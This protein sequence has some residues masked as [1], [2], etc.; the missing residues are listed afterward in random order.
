MHVTVVNQASEAI[1]YQVRASR[2]RLSF[3]GNPDI[4]RLCMY[5]GISYCNY[6]QKSAN[7]SLCIEDLTTP[8]NDIGTGIDIGVGEKALIKFVQLNKEMRKRVTT[9]TVKIRSRF[10]KF[11]DYMEFVIKVERTLHKLYY[12]VLR[13]NP[14]AVLALLP[15]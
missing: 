6:Y 10:P 11:E 15:E 9:L 1:V 4:V 7:L 2:I 13:D 12:A 3:T 14:A 5:K 8:C